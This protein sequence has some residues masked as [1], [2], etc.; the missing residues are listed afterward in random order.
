MEKKQKNKLL[1][2]CDKAN[3]TCDKSQYKEAT[4]LEKFKLFIHLIYCS[5]CREYSANNIKLTNIL[6]NPKAQTM[7]IDEKEA[8]KQRLKEE[9]SK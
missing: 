7:K 8:L 1:I 4:L 6:K 2:P 9:L 5:A 3:H